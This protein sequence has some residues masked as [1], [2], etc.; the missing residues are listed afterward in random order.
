MFN[1]FSFKFFS[2]LKEIFSDVRD[3]TEDIKRYFQEQ[4]KPTLLH[5]FLDKEIKRL[6]DENAKLEEKL[7]FYEDKTNQDSIKNGSERLGFMLGDWK[8]PSTVEEFNAI[9]KL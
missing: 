7:K 6:K 5:F 1:L 4:R 8:A 9:D 2:S 3:E